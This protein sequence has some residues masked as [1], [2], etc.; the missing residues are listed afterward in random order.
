MEAGICETYII[1]GGGPEVGL[2]LFSQDRFHCDRSQLW[3][4]GRL[5]W[6]R[7]LNKRVFFLTKYINKYFTVIFNAVDCC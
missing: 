7:M 3:R 1:S 5:C 2:E 4:L 6:S